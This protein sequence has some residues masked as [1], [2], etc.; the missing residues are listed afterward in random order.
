MT[1]AEAQQVLRPPLR[2]GDPE[3]IQAHEL[4]VGALLALEHFLGCE[5]CDCSP[6][7]C[8]V[9]LATPRAVWVA[10]MSIVEAMDDITLI[11]EFRKRGYD[12]AD[13]GTRT[14]T[15]GGGSS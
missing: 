4:W 1:I 13:E 11:A 10:A 9:R 5:E 12:V 14:G 7:V 15:A 3:Q 2:F 6:P 8:P